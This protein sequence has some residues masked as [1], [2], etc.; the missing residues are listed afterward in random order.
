MQLR[1]R[2]G[3]M[4]RF[5]STLAVLVALTAGL[6]ASCS[7]QDR[8]GDQAT[9]APTEPA[10]EKAT[11]SSPAQE[12]PPADEPA[13]PVEPEAEQPTADP[14]AGEPRGESRPT[15]PTRGEERAGPTPPPDPEPRAEPAPR[16]PEPRRPEPRQPEP[17]RPE[18]DDPS[19]DPSRE[20][21]QVPAS[22][23]GSLPG[24]EQPCD[25]G[26]CAKGLSC[27]EYYGIAGPR[28]PKMSSCEIRCPAGKGCPAGQHC[29]TVSDGPGQVCRP[30]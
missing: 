23:G 27:V 17:R 16:R 10:A 21:D 11:P 1:A 19:R 9:A 4:C 8:K 30:H 22:K 28:G 29:A 24:Q 3:D 5:S 25:G 20:P 13:T 18:P 6:L 7:R 26:R 14:Q 12:E 15:E 2:F